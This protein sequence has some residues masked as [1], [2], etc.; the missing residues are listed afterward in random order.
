MAEDPPFTVGIEEEYLLVDSSSRDLIREVPASLLAQCEARLG[1]RVAPE[2][3]QSQIE[4]GTRVCTSIAEA[5]EELRYLR[6]CIAEAAS[7]HGLI[8]CRQV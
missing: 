2:F 8:S 4:V 7:D 5:R 6:K 1:A 3:L